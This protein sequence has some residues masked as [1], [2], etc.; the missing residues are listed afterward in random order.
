M[1]KLLLILLFF[2]NHSLQ[3]QNIWYVKNGATGNGNSWANASNNLQQVINNATEGDEIWIAQGTY[4]PAI[5]TAFVLNKNVSLY[6]GFSNTGSPLFNDRNPHLYPTILQGNQ[7]HVLR[8]IGTLPNNK[9]LTTTIIDGF[10]ITNGTSDYGGGLLINFCDAEFRNLKIHN[11]T[12]LLGE[13]GGIKIDYSNS[14]FIQVLVTNNN[15]HKITGTDGDSGGIRIGNSA[16]TF[17]NCV[18]ANNHAD[19]YIGGVYSLNNSQPKFYNTIIYGNTADVSLGGTYPNDNYRGNNSV[20]F[21]NCILGGSGGSDKLN[22]NPKWKYGGIDLGGNWDV[23]PLFNTDYTLQPNS[24]AINKGDNALYSTI[25][26]TDLM[27]QNRFQNII[28]IGVM[29]HQL[30]AQ[31]ILYVK[32]GGTGDGSSWTNASGDLQGMIDKQMQGNVVWVAK[33]T[34]KPI[35]GEIYFKMRD[36]IEILGGFDNTGNPTLQDR[37]FNLHETIL[38]SDSYTVIGNYLYSTRF[39]SNTSILD[40]FTILRNELVAQDTFGATDSYSNAVYK[41][42]IFKNFSSAGTFG[43]E[44]SNNTFINCTFKD[45]NMINGGNGA[46]FLLGSKATYQ[47]CSFIDNNAFGG[48]AIQAQNNSEINVTECFFTGNQASSPHGGLVINLIASKFNINASTFQNNLSSNNYASSVIRTDPE[49]YGN[50]TNCIFKDNLK[51]ALYFITPTVYDAN[52]KIVVSNSLFY[53]N[54]VSGAATIAGNGDVYFTNCTFTK[55]FAKNRGGGAVFVG[56]GNVYLRNCILYDNNA[57]YFYVS[58]IHHYPP[59]ANV[60]LQN[61]I[62]KGSGGSLNW[63][64]Q[65]YGNDL[66]N[67][68]DVNPRFTDIEANDFSLMDCSPAIDAGSNTFYGANLSPDLSNISTDLLGNNRF[69]NTV[70]IGAFEFNGN[71]HI[72]TTYYVNTAATGTNDGSNWQNAYTKLE[73]AIGKVC[74]NDEIWIAEGT[75]IP[76]QGKAFSLVD[77]VKIYGGFPSVGD[78]KMDERN[79]NLFKTILKGNENSVFVNYSSKEFPITNE[80]L[81]D[82]F[83]L[84]DGT[85]NPNMLF[86]LTAGGAICNTN[87]SPTLRN[88]IIRNNSAEFGAAIYNLEN[89]NPILI[90]CLIV[91]NEY[92]GPNPINNTSASSVIFNRDTTGNTKLINC[93]LVNNNASAISSYNQPTTLVYNS[94]VFNNN[95]GFASNNFKLAIVYTN[96]IVG[97]NLTNNIWDNNYGING[98]NN[99]NQDPNLYNYYLPSYSVAIDKGNNTFFTQHYSGKYDLQLSDRFHN[100]R[101]DLGAYEFNPLLSSQQQEL[102]NKINIYPNPVTDILNINYDSAEISFL[103]IFSIEGKLI[104]ESEIKPQIN[105]SNLNSGTYILNFYNSKNNLLHSS[106]I[107]KK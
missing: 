102:N 80:T 83:I 7:E 100:S 19:G 25:I 54:D 12:A 2:S 35:N 50:I 74:E 16:P 72:P 91:E 55:N 37:D 8:A 79:W 105:I 59:H 71:T 9:L 73:S 47:Q 96:C 68:I 24:F 32:Q 94:I 62:V 69:T 76:E 89:S 27:Q 13:G 106:K 48:A 10:S 46:S 97:D 78:P 31:P 95:K 60:N 56:S 86:T 5:N 18:I 49:S 52:K 20:E 11:N 41:N 43:R 51:G 44:G 87:A 30:P 85:G 66:G 88:L 104:T 17:I 42:I 103:K 23:D 28:D 53:N 107:I 6:G 81:L 33:G 29:E 67:N 63:N 84:E 65:F 1:K 75:Y 14:K 3:A 93:T 36:G 90:N 58:E 22:G 70:D 26:G 61:C 21:K 45:N 98:G 101:I 64:S 77:K 57:T 34:Y 82:G 40:G 38:S 39:L 15:T 99:L 92:I 4:Q